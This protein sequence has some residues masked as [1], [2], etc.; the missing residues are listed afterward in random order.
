MINSI[1]VKVLKPLDVPVSWQTYLGTATSYITFFC[2]NEQ[3]E[4]WA[5]NDEIATGYYVQ[6]DV[7]SKG[8]N[9][10]LVDQ[11]KLTLEA[12]GFKRT[13]ALDQYESDTQIY[14][15]AMRFNYVI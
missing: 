14:H 13:T 7:W 6:V 1:L 10:P 2:Y 12:E 9:S 8:D 15:K 11:V 4:A 3:G 5:E